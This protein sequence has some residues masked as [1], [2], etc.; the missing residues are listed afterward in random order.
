MP[1]DKEAKVPIVE[2]WDFRWDTKIDK[3]PLARWRNDS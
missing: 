2:Y 1:W 3:L